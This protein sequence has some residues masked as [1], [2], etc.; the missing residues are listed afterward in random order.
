MNPEE[1][2]LQHLPKI[3]QIAAFVARRSHLNADETAEFVQ[4]VRFRLLENDYA[5]IRKF[6]GR[7]LFSTYLTTVIMHLYHQWRVEQWGKWRPSAEAKRLGGKAITLERL[8]TRDGFTFEEA[9]KVLTTPAGSGHTVSELEALYVR[10]PLR[11]PR[12]VLVSDDGLPDAIAVDGDADD[13]IEQC[14]RQRSARIAAKTLDT[15]LGAFD[16]EDRLILQ[17]R[18]WD[19]RKVPEIARTLKLD[20][21]KLYKRLDKLFG[22]LRGELENAHVTR[23]DIHRLL[24]GGDQ[25][26]HLDLISGGGIGSSGHSHSSSGEEVRGGEGRS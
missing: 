4:E 11:N 7:S 25:E 6:E 19:S 18:F 14:D 13:R 15:A 17:M 1:I 21:K 2:Y 3:E 20:Q 10:L 5:V 24:I 23:D 22:R 16:P 12:P 9:V 26:I 8:L